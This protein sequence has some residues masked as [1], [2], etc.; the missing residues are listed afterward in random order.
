MTS[1]DCRWIEIA[2]QLD[3]VRWVPRDVLAAIVMRDGQCIWA[4]TSDD[5]PEL[6]GIDT[7]DRALAARLC[8]RCPVRDECLE[9]ELRTAGKHTTGVWGALGEHDRRAL[10]PH[11]RQRGERAEDLTDPDDMAGGQPT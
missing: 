11:W 1:S 7:T 9:L 2:W 3:R 6:T 5:P 10:Y 8:E 4:Y